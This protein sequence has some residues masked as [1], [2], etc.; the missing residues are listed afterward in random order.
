MKKIIAAL[1]GIS[2][3]LGTSAYAQT[4]T[5]NTWGDKGSSPTQI[6][7]SIAG[8]ANSEYRIQETA[9]D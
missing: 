8:E 5:S 4:T 7:D 3:V 1:I 9:L 2:L 6:L